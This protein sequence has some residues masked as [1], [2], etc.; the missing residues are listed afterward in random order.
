[1]EYIGVYSAITVFIHIDIVCER[2][3]NIVKDI[4]A[5]N[6]Q[7]N[8]FKDSLNEIKDKFIFLR[9]GVIVLI[10]NAGLLDIK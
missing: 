9:C 10:C 3:T 4:Q 5:I 6:R 2:V 1:M 8:K 7:L